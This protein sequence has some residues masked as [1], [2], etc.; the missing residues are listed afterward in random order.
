M[1]GWASQGWA[2]AGW[3][4]AG[5]GAVVRTGSGRMDAGQISRY[6]IISAEV[7]TAGLVAG[8]V[9]RYGIKAGEIR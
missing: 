8:Q 9:N 2:S 3:A 6:G 7:R 5:G 4:L 1:R